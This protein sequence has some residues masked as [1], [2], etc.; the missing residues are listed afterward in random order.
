MV[1]QVRRIVERYGRVL[2][3]LAPTDRQEIPA[4][5]GLAIV[6]G[7]D[8]T[9]LRAARRVVDLD[10]PLVGVNNGRL[11][12]MAEF[13]LQN[14]E[15]FA[16]RI[17]GSGDPAPTQDCMLLRATVRDAQGAT[18]HDGLAIN[19]CVVTA[20]APFE[21]VELGLSIDGAPAPGP[22]GDGLI[23]ATPVG[24]TAYNVSAGGPI[25]HPTLDAMVITPLAAHSLAFR[26][27]VVRGDSVLG[28]DALRVNEGTTLVQDGEPALGLRR[29][30]HVE[31]RRHGPRVHFV[32]N[33]ETSYWSILRTKLRWGVPPSYR[34]DE[35]TFTR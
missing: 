15:A 9:L 17:F 13:D 24:S 27:I 5:A 33:P 11:G 16:P 29:G 10:L 2:G 12:F 4:G 14:L 30:D 8:G 34:E 18:R 35:R 23:V 21:M 1:R 20:G 7:G 28:I 22:R 25:L 31:I 19:D 32:L 3:E 26:P 6:V